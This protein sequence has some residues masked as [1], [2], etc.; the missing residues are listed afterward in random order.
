[1]RYPGHGQLSIVLSF[2]L[3]VVCSGLF[4][5]ASATIIESTVHVHLRVVNPCAMSVIST[6]VLPRV[7]VHCRLPVAFQVQIHQDGV[8]TASNS[9]YQRVVINY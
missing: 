4:T 2:C 7:D 5:P 6:A 3:A 9:H 8:T 1:M